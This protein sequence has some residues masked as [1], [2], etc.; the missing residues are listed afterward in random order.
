MTSGKSKEYTL[1]SRNG[2]GIV[3]FDIRKSLSFKERR[4]ENFDVL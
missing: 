3:D 1:V 2:Q 4:K